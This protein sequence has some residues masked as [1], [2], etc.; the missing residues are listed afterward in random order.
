MIVWYNTPPM[1]ML[2]TVL[3]IA[4]CILLF[5][6]AIFIHEFGHF[7]AARWRGLRVDAFSIGFGPVLWRKTLRGVEWRISAIPFGGYVAIPDVD[8]EGTA[9]V[10]GTDGGSEAEKNGNPVQWKSATPVD[11]IIVA[12]A[13]PMGNVVLAVFLAFFLAMVPGARFG[14][15]PAVIGEVPSFGPAH[16]A[17]MKAGD[18][19]VAVGGVPV[20]TWTEMQTEVQIS[21]GK[22]TEF[23]VVRA[24]GEA[25]LTITPQRQEASGVYLICAL[26]TTNAAKAVA[27]IP[28]RNPLKQLQWDTMSIVRVLKALLTPKESKAAAQALGGPVMIAEGLY[29]QVRSNVWD[30]IGFLRFLCINLAI[31]NLLPIPVLDG[32][33]VMFSLYALVF[34]RKPNEKFVGMLTQVFMYLLIAAMLFLVY[35]DSVRSWR[36]HH[37]EPVVKEAK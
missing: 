20:R 23:T 16:D 21:G 24:D 10:Q 3:A 33:I 5:S 1:D 19:V 34:R 22:P 36:I 27:W 18:R 2:Y 30:A 8:P 25:K 14:E 6:F 35:R 11:S 9:K 7:L 31:L 28:S 4:A 13:G 37:D 12:V 26:S 32:S 29:R 15:L 17:G